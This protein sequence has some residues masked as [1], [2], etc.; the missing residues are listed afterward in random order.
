[1]RQQRRH[2]RALA[3]VL[4]GCFSA[5]GFVP[6]ALTGIRIRLRA[7]R[8][9]P[10]LAAACRPRIRT[11]LLVEAEA[12]VGGTIS[13]RLARPLGLVIEEAGT[14][15][16]GVRVVRIDP[17]G[18]SS[19]G[20]AAG[21]CVN[22]S[23]VGVD[24]RDCAGMG[25]DSVMDAIASGPGDSVELELRRPGDGVVEWPNG[26]A[27]A[28]AAGEYLGNVA[29]EAG[30]DRIEY[31]CRSGS[32][33]TCGQIVRGEDGRRRV[34]RPCVARVRRGRTVVEAGQA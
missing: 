29:M 20:G 18:N 7:D 23:I 4:A 31:S 11:E 9:A 8:A 19:G 21:I 24:G 28:A 15:G 17:G 5:S 26:V 10:A 33:G 25:F 16:E 22:D 13:V 14:P 27:V 2:I 1:M 34:A 3:A 30:Y 32:C 6:R 12:A